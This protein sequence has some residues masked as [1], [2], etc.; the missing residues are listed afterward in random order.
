VSSTP[1]E[2]NQ[3][4]ARASVRVAADSLRIAKVNLDSVAQM[5]A[6]LF[7]D[8]ESAEAKQAQTV[9]PDI[10]KLIDALKA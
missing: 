1:R 7:I 3:D 9:I 4:S 6:A 10:A 2:V 8:P 5:S